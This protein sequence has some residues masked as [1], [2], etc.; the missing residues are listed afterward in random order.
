MQE[1]GGLDAIDLVVVEPE[2]AGDDLD[3]LED[4]LGVVARVAVALAEC[5]GQRRHGVAAL[6]LFGRDVV[7]L[8]AGRDP[9]PAQFAR[10][11]KGNVGGADRGLR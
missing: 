1:R 8:H 11:V 6:A 3:E 5:H 9:V 2:P 10:M 7:G 4:L